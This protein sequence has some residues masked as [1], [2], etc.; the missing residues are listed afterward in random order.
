VTVEAAA[1]Q[2]Y[3]DDNQNQNERYNAE[4]FYPARRSFILLG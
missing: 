4:H 1:S 2:V 3:N